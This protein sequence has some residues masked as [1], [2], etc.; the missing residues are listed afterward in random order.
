MDPRDAAA[1]IRRLGAQGA[2]RALPRLLLVGITEVSTSDAL[3][4]VRRQDEAAADTRWYPHL[5]TY[6]PVA[7]DV[8]LALEDG[9]MLYVLGNIAGAGS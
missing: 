9:N 2:Q 4:K 1:T 8:S 6:S 5:K 3:V 7:G